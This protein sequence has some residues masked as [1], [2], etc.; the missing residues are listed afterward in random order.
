MTICQTPGNAYNADLYEKSRALADCILDA[1]VLSTGINYEYVWETDSMS[2][3]NWSQVPVTIVE[4]GYMTNS[5]EDLNMQDS[6]MQEKMVDGIANGIDA[7]MVQYSQEN[8]AEEKE[9]G[10][11]EAEE[12]ETAENETKEAEENDT[13]ETEAAENEKVEKEAGKIDTEVKETAE[14]DTEEK[15]AGKNDTEEKETAENETKEN[16]EEEKEA[17]VNETGEE[18]DE[19]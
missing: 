3:I 9:T 5:E 7:Y 6:D 10:E 17:A 2:G 15:E 16:Q 13:E 1:Y 11:N 12:R 18:K 8:E 4:L 14:N 19:K